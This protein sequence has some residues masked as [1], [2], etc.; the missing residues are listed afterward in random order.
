MLR[1]TPAE[2]RA[3]LVLVGLLA[4]GAGYDLWRS[5]RP[6]VSGAGAAFSITSRGGSGPDSEEAPLAG[7]REGPDSGAAASATRDSAGARAALDL[8]RA[9]AEDLDELPGV[10][11]VIAQRIVDFRRHH[12]PFRRVEDLRAV[13]GIGPRLLERLRPKVAVGPAGGGR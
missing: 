2:R 6:P 12:G 9:T 5:R 1:F 11:P 8:N 10:G 7:G 13:R 3:I 4:L